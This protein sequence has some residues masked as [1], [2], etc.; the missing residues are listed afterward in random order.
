[1]PTQFKDL[2]SNILVLGFMYR[3]HIEAASKASIKIL[4]AQTTQK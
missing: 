1:M 3:D 2:M 4:F